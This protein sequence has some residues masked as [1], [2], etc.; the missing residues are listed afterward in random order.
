MMN[1]LPL[2]SVVVT[3]YNRAVWLT[4]ALDSVAAQHHRPLEIVVVDNGSTDGAIQ[5]AEQWAA[6][7]R[8]DA[9]RVLVLEEQRPG[10][11]AARN[12]GWRKAEGEWIAFFDD[13][14]EMSPHF[15]DH[16]LSTARR[17]PRAQWVLARSQ[18]VAPDGQLIA[19]QGW[20]N[21]SLAAHLLGAFVTTQ[22]LLVRKSVLEEI[23]GWNEQL[24]LWNDYEIGLRLL[25]HSRPAWDAGIYHRLYQHPISITYG[26]DPRK[27]HF[28]Q[29]ALLALHRSLEQHHA[30]RRAFRAL[31]LRR[32]LECARWMKNQGD[33]NALDAFRRATAHFSTHT[34]AFTRCIG[35][36]L[37]RRE[38]RGGRANW[39]LACLASYI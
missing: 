10:V 11:S 1:A 29:L 8:S 35:R 25:L 13:D 26:I 38:L 15:V 2:V 6:Q 37:S 31:Y 9:L 5:C 20:R 21:P 30:P 18:M 32:E 16:L 19:R 17:Q 7:H 12:L 14:D 34:S 36:W 4:R 23:N 3:S 24:P 39:L 27:L 22:S 28:R 33:D